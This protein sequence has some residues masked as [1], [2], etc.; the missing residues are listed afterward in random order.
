MSKRVLQATIRVSE[1]PRVRFFRRFRATETEQQEQA[2]SPYID[3]T[4]QVV[5]LILEDMEDA[6]GTCSI[7]RL[8]AEGNL[9]W[10]TRHPSIQE[11]KWAVEFEYGLPE[12]KWTALS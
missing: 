6:A 2:K 3:V 9:V 1:Y 12:E 8:D 4:R 11:A 7:V 10:R 5:K